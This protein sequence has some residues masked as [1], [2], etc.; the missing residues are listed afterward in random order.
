M[1]LQHIA[2]QLYADQKIATMNDTW[3]HL[4]P[5]E[6]QLYMGEVLFAH[7]CYNE[8]FVI[9]WKFKDLN[10]SPWFYDCLNDFIYECKTIHGRIYKFTGAFCNYKFEGELEELE[11][12]N[13]KIQ[14][15]S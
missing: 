9:D 7:N 13:I 6:N 11:Y 12:E 14:S 4:A 10:S 15:N 8:K 2:P 1:G 5:K 3:G